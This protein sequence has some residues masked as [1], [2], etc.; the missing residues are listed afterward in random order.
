M[1]KGTFG[2]A[3]APPPRLGASVA[4]LA[5]VLFAFMCL[6]L[7]ELVYSS[8]SFTSREPYGDVPPYGRVLL[9]VAAAEPPA[10]FLGRAAARPPHLQMLCSPV[11]LLKYSR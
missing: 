9:S 4:P 8:H 10:P 1:L 6:L 11:S 2:V 3:A 7:R 5:D